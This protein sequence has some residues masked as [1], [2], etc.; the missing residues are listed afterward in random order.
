MSSSTS[1][2]KLVKR[3]ASKR[4]SKR[5]ALPDY[6]CEN[7]PVFCKAPPPDSDGGSSGWASGEDDPDL[8][9]V[10]TTPIGNSSGTTG[11]FGTGT[12]NSNLSSGGGGGGNPD[13]DQNNGGGEIGKIKTTHYVDYVLLGIAVVGVGLG[14]Y[15]LSK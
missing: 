4:R 9:P 8:T 13:T 7:D 11:G 6:A 1:A 2:V 3:K 15:L 12:T 5:S 10:A 14:I